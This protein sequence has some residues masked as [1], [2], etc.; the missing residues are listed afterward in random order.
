M[1]NRVK[2][3]IVE[4][5]GDTSGLQ[6]ALTKVNGITNTLNK[7]LK[8]INK[9]LKLDPDNIELLG[10]KQST[11]NKEIKLTSK[12]LDTLKAHYD[13]TNDYIAEGNE[14]TE[15]QEKNYRALQREI[16][17]VESKLSSLR[18]EA[19]NWNKAGEALVDFGNK[20]SN[21]SGK[22]DKLGTTLTTRLTLPLVAIG[23]T[24]VNSA[25]EFETAFTGVTKTV[26]GTEEQIENLKQG[27][28]DLSEEIPSSTTEISA[29]AEAAGQL[30]IKTENILDFS[31]AMI[32]LGNSTNLSAEEA[33]SQLA[34]FANIMN[35]SQKDFEK[36]GS[37]IV[38][39]G[40]NFATTE[41]DIVN[42]SMRLAGAGKQVGL[43]EGQVL[44]LATALSSV[45]IEAEMGGSAISKAMVKMQNAVEQGGTKLDDVL[46][47][48]GMTLRDLELMAA[49]D[50]KS[51]REMS[52][53][54]GMTSTEVKQLITAGTNLEDFSKISGMT[55]EEFKKAWKEDAAGA[56]SAFI[57]GLGDAESK[58]ESA[59]TMLSEMGLTEVRLRDS[60]L[61]AANAGELF[62]D[63]IKTGTKAWNENTALVEEAEKRYKTLDSRLK[64]TGNKFKN[65]ATNMGNK[66]TP[67][68]NKLL[69][70]VDDLIDKFDDLSE[71]ETENIIKTGAMIAAIGPATKIISAFG[72]TA[73]A[74]ITTLGNFSKAIANVKN[75]VKTAEGQVG[76]FTKILSALTTPTGLAVAGITA[77][78]TVT[79][80]YAKKTA[81]EITSLNGVRD[82]IDNQK[83]S[84]ENLKQ[85][86]ENSL[87]S[88]GNE[89]FILES[90]ANELNTIVD[91]NGK[92]K[93]GYEDRANFIVTTLNNALGTE[94]SLNDGIIKDYQTM[95]NEIDNIIEKKKAEILLN[96]YA[97]EYA[98]A[99]RGQG[100]ATSNLRDLT[101]QMTEAQKE[102]AAAHE[103]E[104]QEVLFKIGE[105]E[106]AIKEEKSL[107]D[108][109]QYTIGNY[110][111]LQTASISGTAEQLNLALSN[112]QVSWQQYQTDTA[113]EISK[114]ST[115]VNEEVVK[116]AT[117]LQN[118]TSVSTAS[119]SLASDANRF[120]ITELNKNVE[121]TKEDLFNVK[122]VIDE[123]TEVERASG[124]L[125]A[126]SAQTFKDNANS[127]S[128]G[129]DFTIGIAQGI[130]NRSGEVF[131]TVY[132]LGQGMIAELRASI[133]SH[134]PSKESMDIGEDFDLGILLGVKNKKKKVLS[135]IY[136]LGTSSLDALN[137]SFNLD[138][139][140]KINGSLAT[141]VI[142]GS[143]TIF[144]TPNLT[145]YTQ[146]F[147]A[148][149]IADEVNKIFGSA[150]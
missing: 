141:K 144:T 116:V 147:D 46:K 6:K 100:E 72:N 17:N 18:A 7:E 118:D 50:S 149:K 54:I 70:K 125:G 24:L 5:G 60:L 95:Q 129:E 55:A 136:D 59:I 87:Q 93:A 78:T 2:G 110:E 133:N 19:S 119:K 75:G 68:A 57:K 10:Q 58:G 120:F 130:N 73:G 82:A 102:L 124:D 83:D 49:N 40:N 41:A 134:S 15:E 51:F 146:E 111:A 132:G 77:L 3:I 90:L 88:T 137:N 36:L 121:G 71:E 92:V 53:S 128:V 84:W 80:M 114:T 67:S 61:R 4:I 62:N 117:I 113:L 32:N 91:S 14:L 63:A 85:T 126:D 22:L 96:A 33:A 8:N 106:K 148:R 123:D 135:E 20:V 47:K 69:D 30:G 150:Y 107:L 27:I 76:T 112:M 65:L 64:T 39:L 16:V 25:K 44:G 97:D 104:K 101:N 9:S 81:S 99:L 115:A 56:L 108:E 74:T 89:I 109:Y 21:I 79:Y 127:T 140:E 26:D 122:T 31:K 45:G 138:N 43:S 34:R 12:E 143:K 23:T 37:A 139:I 42:M 86:R 13:A 131:S 1:A 52:Q 28:K 142:D 48:T 11:L 103:K 35:M 66:L 94:M 145:I 38:D 105:I 29:V 98:E